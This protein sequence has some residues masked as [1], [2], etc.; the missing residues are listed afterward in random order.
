MNNNIVDWT[1]QGVEKWLC[2]NNKVRIGIC[3]IFR[4]KYKI[5]GKKLIQLS[6]VQIK[7][8]CREAKATHHETYHVMDI[9]K[10]LQNKHIGKQEVIQQIHNKSKKRKRDSFKNNQRNSIQQV[11]RRKK[12]HY[13]TSSYNQH[14]YKY[15]IADSKNKNMKNYGKPWHE[16]DYREIWW[17]WLKY[18]DFE[19]IARL[20][21][22]SYLACLTKINL[23]RRAIAE[24]N[25][26]EFGLML[27]DPLQ[28][29]EYSLLQIAREQ[30]KKERYKRQNE[31]IKRESS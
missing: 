14:H 26:E 15:F 1:T 25:D 29:C 31:R 30:Q 6:P 13:V 21:N 23:I 18:R 10:K 19:P 3:G 17:L 20:A 9:I 7:H 16:K 4:H 28:H 5:D 22:R 12:N 11:K 27:N 8:C 24:S 2:N